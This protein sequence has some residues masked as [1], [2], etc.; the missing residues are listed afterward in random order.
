M[1]HEQQDAVANVHFFTQLYWLEGTFSEVC[2]I[3]QMR[4][5]HIKITIRHSDWWN[6]ETNSPLAMR[7][8]WSDNLKAIEGWKGLK[9]SWKLWKETKIRKPEVLQSDTFLILIA[10]KGKAQRGLGVA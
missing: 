6:W 10:G 2:K 4:P 5:K 9:L 8:E 7:K 3:P 1:T